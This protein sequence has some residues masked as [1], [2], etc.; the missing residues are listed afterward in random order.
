[1]ELGRGL[2]ATFDYQGPYPAFPEPAPEGE[3]L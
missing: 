1:M 3:T 2:S